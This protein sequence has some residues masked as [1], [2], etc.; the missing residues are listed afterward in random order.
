MQITSKITLYF[1]PLS[2]S[3]FSLITFL[4]K[5]YF[6]ISPPVAVWVREGEQTEIKVIMAHPLQN[7]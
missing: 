1:K 5:V 2:P 4:H 7:I 3:F 6:F